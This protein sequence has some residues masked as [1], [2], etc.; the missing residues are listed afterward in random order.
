[1]LEILK[2]IY[3]M[4][5]ELSFGQM[6]INIMANGIMVKHMAMEQKYGKMEQNI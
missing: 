1:M 6:G 2:I 3:H 4:V 5:T